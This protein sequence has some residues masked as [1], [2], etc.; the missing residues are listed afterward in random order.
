LT[1]QQLPNTLGSQ[2]GTG[3]TW[4]G[5]VVYLK[6]TTYQAYT[7]GMPADWKHLPGGPYNEQDICNSILSDLLTT[8]PSFQVGDAS[9]EVYD[10][11]D[12]VRAKTGSGGT[13]ENP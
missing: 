3:A 2:V 8:Q 7:A 12:V 11:K 13:C 4:P 1:E 5:L 6:G 9:I 10:A